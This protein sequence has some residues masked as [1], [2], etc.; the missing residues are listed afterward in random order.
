MAGVITL[1]DQ[2]R[3]I[4]V[5]G[6]PVQGVI[7]FYYTGTTNYAPIYSDKALTTPAANP[8]VLAAGQLFPDIFLD[9]TIT[10][11]RRI[12][13][14]DGGIHDVDPL[15]LGGSSAADISFIQAGADAKT[16]TMQDKARE[17][18]SDADF[19]DG[20]VDAIDAVRNLSDLTFS[21][22]VSLPNSLTLPSTTI[23]L[24]PNVVRV[25]GVGFPTYWQT[26][27]VS[28]FSC[29]GSSHTNNWFQQF[30]TYGGTN[31]FDITTVGEIA[32]NKYKDLHHV[33]FTGDCYK[34]TGGLTSSLFENVIIDGNLTGDRGIYTG[35]GINNDNIVRAC[36]FLSL[37]GSAIQSVNLTQGWTIEDCRVENGGLNGQTVFDFQGAQGVKIKGGWYEGH[38]ETLL[39][40]TG[41]SNGGVVIDGIVD[42]GATNGGGFKA[43]L[44]NVGTNLVTFGTNNW[45]NQT[46]A[47]LNCLIYGLNE[48][49]YAASSNVWEHK[50]QRGG[51]VH[52]R[53]RNT[54]VDTATFDILTVTRSTGSPDALT[55]LQ[56][57]SGVITLTFAGL[58]GVVAG[59]TEKFPVIVTGIGVDFRMVIGSSFGAVNAGAGGITFSVAEKVGG[60]S[61]SRTMTVTVAG[62]TPGQSLINA[63]FEFENNSNF[64]SNLI[65]VN[66][67]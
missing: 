50:S 30:R 53:Q 23:D 29:S 55:N 4:G 25:F 56:T 45:N 1:L 9:E 59:R 3:L 6:R 67:L 31:V 33:A 2:P 49:L 65:V 20:L 60:T 5:D 15:P 27:P 36:S 42:I 38:H 48:N 44:F 14:G 11:R 19:E 22:A 63:S 39:K 12:E 62:H 41:S 51:K 18:V 32:S 47:P 46:T 34:F 16:R 26:N 37:T 24:L 61:T 7:R 43:S 8:I 64:A 35:G 28:V 54:A 17:L 10:Y 40:L 57:L 13:Y 58:N 52:L 66:P 21:G